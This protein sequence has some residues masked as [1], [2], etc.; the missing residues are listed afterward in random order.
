GDKTERHCQSKIACE[1]RQRQI[2]WISKSD[3]P[4][5]YFNSSPE[6][7]RLV[8]MIYARVPLSLRNVEDLMFGRG[9][10]ICHATVRFW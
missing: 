4:F 9:I 6:I 10:N 1:R 2:R 5:R 7:L 3:N 8:V